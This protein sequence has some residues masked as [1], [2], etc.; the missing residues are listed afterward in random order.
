MADL[1][2]AHAAIEEH[3][4]AHWS[5]TALVFEN[6]APP[7]L[8]GPDGFLLPWV[9]CEIENADSGLKT[10]G[11][12]GVGLVIDTGFI[13]LTVFVRRGT[14]RRL[15]R[16]MAVQLADIVDTEILYRVSP[17][18]YVRTWTPVIGRGNPAKSENPNGNW[19]AINIMTPFNFYH[20]S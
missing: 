18:E 13:S 5:T 19:W 1:L 17:D 4:A 15:A 11:G 9:L 6:E 2:G 3:V 7:D 10:I 16:E 8:V 12:K 20:R 14:G